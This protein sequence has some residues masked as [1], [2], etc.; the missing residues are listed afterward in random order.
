MTSTTGRDLNFDQRVKLEEIAETHPDAT[1][2]GWHKLDSEGR[3]GPIVR[4]PQ[5]GSRRYVNH[6]GRVNKG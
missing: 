3:Y 2:V 1:V 5:D 6:N 4:F